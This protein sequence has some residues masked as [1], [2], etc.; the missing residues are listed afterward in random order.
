MNEI[1]QSAREVIGQFLRQTRE[2]KGI[3]TY[4]LRLK[5]KLNG[6]QINQIETGSH[7]YTIDTLL[8]YIAAVDV[9]IFFADKHGKEDESLDV[10]HMTKAAAKADP[11]VKKKKPRR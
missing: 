3:K 7:N 4:Q 9:Y 1:N 8:R 5:G 2:E 11:K 10:A 6:E